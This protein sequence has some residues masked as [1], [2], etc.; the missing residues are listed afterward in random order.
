MDTGRRF[1]HDDSTSAGEIA[2]PPSL[3]SAVCLRLF[4]V[5]FFIHHGRRFLVNDG[6]LVHIIRPDQTKRL[7]C[8]FYA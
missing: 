2:P 5:L 7:S 1:D 3:Q 6:Y 8:L 4:P